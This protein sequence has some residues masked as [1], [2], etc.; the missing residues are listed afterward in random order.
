M[1]KYSVSNL[2][3]LHAIVHSMSDRFQAKIIRVILRKLRITL[4]VQDCIL[5]D[6]SS[7][8]VQEKMAVSVAATVLLSDADI[9]AM[10][11]GDE[12]AAA[13]SKVMCWHL[14]TSA[15][16]TA[17]PTARNFGNELMV[18]SP[19][20]WCFVIE[21]RVRVAGGSCDGRPR[22]GQADT[23]VRECSDKNMVEG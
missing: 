15:R 5:S 4:E 9:C 22:A 6:Q 18:R 13:A 23:G 12:K 11:N 2:I 1:K 8:T 17:W 19:E 20:C 21:G 14:L 7:E 10:S 3:Q 16:L